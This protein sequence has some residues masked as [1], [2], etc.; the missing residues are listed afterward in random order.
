MRAKAV[1]LVA[2][3]VAGCSSGGDPQDPATESGEGG[4]PG[5][6]GGKGGNTGKP[7]QGGAQSNAG[8]GGSNASQG[9]S[10]GQGGS[11]AQGGSP[12]Q[13]GGAGATSPDAAPVDASPVD[14]GAPA[15]AGAAGGKA[16]LVVGQVPLIGSDIQIHEQ[17]VSRG[18]EVEDLLDSKSTTANATGKSIVVISYSVDSEEIAN[19][20]TEVPVPIII[21]EQNLLGV[22]GMT[23]ATGHGYTLGVTEITITKPGSP[24]AAGFTGNV[25]VFTKTGE[26][27]WGTPGPNAI[28]VASAKGKSV[29]F[30]YEAGVMMVGR[31]APA[32]RL[33]FFLGAHLVPDKWLNANGLKLLDAAIDWSIR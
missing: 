4:A 19:K 11:N 5:A 1:L 14:Q 7:G 30:A 21:M 31:M 24:L 27:F 15:E 9:G 23:S 20:F 25:S 2:V 26:T 12:G 8:Q 17:L 29:Y 3:L 22:L 18:L 13:G 10:P 16:L 33:Q 6:G 28:N 32:R